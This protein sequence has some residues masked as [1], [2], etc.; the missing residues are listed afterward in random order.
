M[1]VYIAYKS[2]PAPNKKLCPRRGA[3][4]L[5]IDPKCRRSAGYSFDLAEATDSLPLFEFSMPTRSRIR[6]GS[7]A[8]QTHPRTMSAPPATSFAPT[9]SPRRAAAK[10]AAQMGSVASS[11]DASEEAILP[12]ARVSPSRL[13]A[14]VMSPVHAAAA[15][16]ARR[17]PPAPWTPS[18]A[19]VKR[20]GR[21]QIAR[22]VSSSSHPA[23]SDVANGPSPSPSAV[24]QRAL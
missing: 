17:L 10:A 11:T 22:R 14:V 16:T 23:D 1:C 7:T 12:R 9:A 15:A 21:E 2:M 20:P 6:C 19:D 18:S 8:L 5:S 4:Q 13:A 3:L 24:A